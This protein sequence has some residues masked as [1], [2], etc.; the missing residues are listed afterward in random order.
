MTV[1]E[2]RA[3]CTAPPSVRPVVNRRRRSFHPHPQTHGFPGHLRH[4][5][6]LAALQML[7]LLANACKLCAQV[8]MLPLQTFQLLCKSGVVGASLV[9]SLCGGFLI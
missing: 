6:F 7:K 4:Q 1:S 3:A 8:Q 9:Q 2:V 5:L